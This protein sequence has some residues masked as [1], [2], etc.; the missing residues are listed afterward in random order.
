M[1]NVLINNSLPSL[2]MDAICLT[3]IPQIGKVHEF[4]SMKKMP[5]PLPGK[6]EVLVKLSASAMHIDEI[7]AAQG[8]A[9]GRFYGPKDISINS[10]CI[11]GSSVSG[12][13]VKTGDTVTNIA[14]GDEV[15]AIPSEH[16]ERG[17]WANYRVLD[18]SMVIHKPEDLNH[19]EAAASTMAACVAWGAIKVA[20]IKP[21]DDCVVVGASGAIGSMMVQFLKSLDCH[22]TAVC[23]PTN[24]SYVRKLGAHEVVDYT[25]NDFASLARYNSV[26]YDAVFD[27]IGGKE[28][29]KSAFK[30]LKKTG[31]FATLVGPKQYIGEEKLSWR[32]LCSVLWHIG[33]RMLTTR[34][35][36]GPVYKFAATYPKEIIDE[37]FQV[38]VE[39]GI[40]MP[41]DRIIPFQLESVSNA[42]H[43]LT[44]HRVKGR[45]VISFDCDDNPSFVES[46][47]S[48]FHIGET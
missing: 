15:V 19:I 12:I 11:L 20:R 8:S 26:H 25:I 37:A 47:I 36:K 41:I 34:F 33:T 23:G 3:E 30:V 2:D 10:P 7:Y 24:E 32:E 17:S 42:I 45:I 18:K 21:R 46:N 39:K 6:D 38:L 29:E 16:V 14:I 31:V 27:C 1:D 4:I 44:T 5:I 48:S 13:V 28:I 22:I 43:H 9:L 35:G 40:K